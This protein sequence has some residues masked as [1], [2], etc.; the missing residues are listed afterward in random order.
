MKIAY[1]VHYYPKVS[2]S[3]IRREIAAL[4]AMGISVARFSIRSCESE[5]VDP[6]DILELAKT[7]IILNTAKVRLLFN[8]LQLIVSRPVR[9]WNALKLTCQI[10]WGS[11]RGLLRNLMYLVEAC[12]LVKWLKAREISHL[13]A[14]FGI[15]P[16]AVAM[17]CHVLGDI[18]YSFTV[19]GPKEFDSATGLALSAK[20]KRA[21]FVAA[22][23]SFGKSQLYR[24]CDR[25]D[26]SKIH[27][28]RCGL[29]RI[30]LNYPFES[31]PETPQLV[32]VGRLCEQKGQLLLIEAAGRLAK[33]GLDFKLVLVGDGPLRNEIETLIAQWELADRVE[34][35]GWASNSEVQK[36]LLA[37][38]AMVLPSFAEGLPVVIMEALALGRPVISTYVAGIPEL[39]EP[40]VCGWLVKPGSI[41]DLVETMQAALQSPIEEL[42]QMGKT[43]IQ[44]VAKYHDVQQEAL[45]LATLLD[46]NDSMVTI[47]MK[48]VFD[49]PQDDSKVPLNR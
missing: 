14:H 43:G 21:Q 45:K 19:H 24:W 17:L 35:T 12:S 47:P 23:S 31:I 15:N 33:Q 5:L 16:A 36:H 34:I 6:A 40:G 26:W 20:I 18:S 48:P 2:H 46:Y 42:E 25:S 1:L 44:R 9:F 8:V 32:C 41:D 10:G 39:V 3:F 37:S 7:K 38:R 28:V 22:I 27:V 4:E 49:A 13:H 29:D 11:D 30:F